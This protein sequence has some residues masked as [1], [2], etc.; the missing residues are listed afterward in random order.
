M[1]ARYLVRDVRDAL[2]IPAQTKIG[3]PLANVCLW[4]AAAT[5]T[6]RISG[7]DRPD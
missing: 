5:S 3:D 6:V 1:I 4:N 7:L 2:L